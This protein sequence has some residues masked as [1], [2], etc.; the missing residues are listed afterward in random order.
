MATNKQIYETLQ[1][2]DKNLPDNNIYKRS[3]VNIQSISYNQSV[4]SSDIKEIRRACGDRR[5]GCG[6]N[7]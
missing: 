2:I 6:N 1:S 7:K 3:I 5:F 4:M